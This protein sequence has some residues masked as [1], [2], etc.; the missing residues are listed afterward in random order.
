MHNVIVVA[1]MAKKPLPHR[2]E[3]CPQKKRGGST[4]RVT[5]TRHTHCAHTRDTRDTPVNYTT[6]VG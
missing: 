4:P 3:D 1:L 6:V 2:T 5:D